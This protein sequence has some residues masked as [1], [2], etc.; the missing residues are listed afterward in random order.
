[1]IKKGELLKYVFRWM[2]NV[3]L[4]EIWTSLILTTSVSVTGKPIDTTRKVPKLLKFFREEY[5]DQEIPIPEAYD[6]E[7][8][9]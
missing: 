2:N 4:E 9:D 1:M 8:V 3:S 6:Q 7:Q 5:T